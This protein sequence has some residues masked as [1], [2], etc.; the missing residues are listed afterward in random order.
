[1]RSVS[2]NLSRANKDVRL[3]DMVMQHEAAPTDVLSVE[4][5]A[6]YG[7]GG[8]IDDLTKRYEKAQ[9]DFKFYSTFAGAL[10]GLVF[11]F[12]LISLSLKR[13]RKEYEIDYSACVAC[14][15][16]FS[17]CPLNITNKNLSIQGNNLQYLHK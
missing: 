6:F 16:C 14:T 8:T 2:S 1:M 17:Y 4:L 12:T 7:Q 9:V 13:T 5:D 15:R 3:Y 11:G 10:I